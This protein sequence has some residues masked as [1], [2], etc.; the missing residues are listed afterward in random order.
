MFAVFSEATNAVMVARLDPRF[1]KLEVGTKNLKT[2]SKGT[3][4]EQIIFWPGAMNAMSGV[5]HIALSEA[6]GSQAAPE[7][8]GTSLNLLH[9]R[10]P[11]IQKSLILKRYEFQLAGPFAR[12]KYMWDACNQVTTL[13]TSEMHG[14][15]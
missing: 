2:T 7:M 5:N 15:I 6:V 13:T 3:R 4:K 1:L 8:T 12:Q 14:S 9:W 11:F 10:H